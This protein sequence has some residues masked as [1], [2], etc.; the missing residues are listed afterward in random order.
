MR[1]RIVFG[2]CGA[3]G[4]PLARAVL[5]AFQKV[6]DLET[7]LVL[8]PHAG[9]V[10]A[11]ECRAESSLLTRLAFRVYDPEDMSAGP[12]SGSW[13][14]EGM[15]ICPCSMSSLAAIA[16]G[17]G[18]NLIHRAADVTLKERRPLVLVAR[19]TPLSLIHLNNMR[20]ASEAGATI[21]PFMPA[22]Y[23][24]EDSLAALM[25]AFAGRLLDQ[26]RIPHQ[27]GTRWRENR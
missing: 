2:V 15:I 26:I 18:S 4:M 6:P 10:L 8:S 5:A 19:E 11:A 12:A 7:H 17:C 14:H 9:Q 1:H 16:C 24:G 20:M 25:T 27:L 21:M 3:T 23:S 13:Q 22:F